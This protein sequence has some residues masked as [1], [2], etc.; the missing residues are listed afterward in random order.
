MSYEQYSENAYTGDVESVKNRIPSNSN[1]PTPEKVYWPTK[2]DIF[3]NK[4]NASLSDFSVI[5]RHSTAELD[6][7]TLYLHHR[8]ATNGSGGFMDITTTDGIIDTGATDIYQKTVQ[9]STLPTNTQ[10]D[11]TYTASA[12]KIEDSHINALQNAVM[13]MQNK[14]GLQVPASEVGT[15]IMSMPLVSTQDVDTLVDFQTLQGVL[16]NLVLTK[17]LQNDFY[18]TSTND[19]DIPAQNVTIW[20]GNTGTVSRDQAV[21]DFDRIQVQATNTANPN[22]LPSGEYIYSS[23][24]GDFVGFSGCAEFAS[25]VVIGM[26]YGACI[27]PLEFS[28]PEDEAV[29]AFYS[30]AALAVHGGIWYG[31]GLSGNG[32]VT[33]ITTTGQAVEVVGSFVASTLSVS[34]TATFDGKVHV[35]DELNV[36][37]PGRMTSSNDITMAAK[38]DGTPSKIDGL[39]ASYAKAALEHNPIINGALTQG[40]RHDISEQQQ[41]LYTQNMKHHPQLGIDM[42]PVVG[43]WTYTGVVNFE[44]AQSGQ[45]HNVILLEAEMAAIGDNYPNGAGRSLGGGSNPYGHYC[46]GLFNPGDT[47]IEFDLPVGNK[48]RFSYPIYHHTAEGIAG[49]S[50]TGLNVYIAADDNV[51]E[52]STTL[53]GKW[54]RL[55]QPGNVPLDHLRADGDTAF[56]TSTAPAV[57]LGNQNTSDYPGTDIKLLTD[58]MWDG[59]TTVSDQKPLHKKISAGDYVSVD[60]TDAFTKSIDN[61]TPGASD[62]KTGVAYIYATSRPGA[63][64]TQEANVQLRATPTPY[65]LAS[66]YVWHDGYDMKPGQHC[67]VGEVWATTTDATNWTLLEATPYRPDGFYDS[68]WVPM[69]EYRS[70]AST[71]TSIPNELGRCLP[72][73]GSRTSTEYGATEENFNF[74][75]E[76]NLGPVRGGLTEIDYKVWI[77]SYKSEPLG[78]AQASHLTGETLYKRSS[79]GDMNLW[80]PPVMPYAATHDFYTAMDG[81]DG[82]LEDITQLARIRM[83]DSRFAMLSIDDTTLESHQYIRVY[84]SRIR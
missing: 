39:D 76:H 20:L 7:S 70:A 77:A 35:N 43:G 47:F 83:I 17:H 21:F 66:Q 41:T 10:F 69:V 46:T 11:I 12:D 22:G 28:V 29:G 78:G 50:L 38:P 40:V 61:E 5:E 84:I 58:S 9:F 72:I 34:S 54:Y 45:H 53:A 55:Y 60:L 23:N 15:G 3:V 73:L 52:D 14:L 79:A 74:W 32:D 71:L 62:P 44:K 63:F 51:F 67:A 59:G 82:H 6:G 8:P 80:T 65:G 31:S 81:S 33:F 27:D 68:G 56:S 19:P 16:P 24:T 42:Y 37:Y 18:L 13:A 49:G 1:A 4:E 30:G 64:S 75:V 25:R 2:F 48:N 36:N 26:P 57:R